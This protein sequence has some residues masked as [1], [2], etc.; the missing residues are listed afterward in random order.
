MNRTGG[1][2]KEQ[3]VALVIE[4]WGEVPKG[5]TVKYEGGMH[6]WVIRDDIECI[7]V[8]TT[9]AGIRE[10]LEAISPSHDIY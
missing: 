2:L 10:Q 1:L 5:Y 3:V 8:G 6:T 7:D 4:I 9:V